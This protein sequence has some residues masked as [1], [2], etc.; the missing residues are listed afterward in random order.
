MAQYE[1]RL[2]ISVKNID[3][4]QKLNDI[5]LEPFGIHA[6]GNEAFNLS[7]KDWLIDD[8]S[9]TEK[10]LKKF[11]MELSERL[12]R[13]G[14]I[15]ADTTNINEDPY[16]YVV[17]FAGYDVHAKRFNYDD[18][19]FEAPIDNLAEYLNYGKHFSFSFDEIK[20][21]KKFGIRTE[22]EGRNVIYKEILKNEGLVDEIYLADTN[23]DE[24]IKNIES[25][26]VG[27]DVTL[28]HK[29]TEEYN[30]LIEV[31]KE[32]KTIGLLDFRSAKIMAPI[33]DEGEQEFE[34]RIVSVL[35]L[36]KRKKGRHS[37]IVSIH[38]ELIIPEEK[39]I[40][41]STANIDSDNSAFSYSTIDNIDP[42]FY[43]G[44]CEK[45]NLFIGPD[46]TITVAKNDITFKIQ[47]KTER[48]MKNINKKYKKYL[49]GEYGE[50]N[51]Y[52]PYIALDNL[53][54]SDYEDHTESP[55]VVEKSTETLEPDQ[56]AHRVKV[57]SKI[58]EMMKDTKNLG[59][60]IDAVPKKKNN[61]L[62]IRRVTPITSMFVMT[63]DTTMLSLCA[64]ATDDK[65]LTLEIRHVLNNN[66]DKFEN[67]I[68][69]STNLFR[70]K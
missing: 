11:V 61:T 19:C 68:V 69:M 50:G 21:L 57:F 31:F 34:S 37:A 51:Y 17:Y 33:L 23:T 29:G 55:Y 1:S 52:D 54:Q 16:A 8:W 20:M 3:A 15:F 43:E 25:L 48:M 5:D 28:I 18:F 64:K 27:D 10:D 2:R 42:R 47:I 53:V 30:N 70:T 38:I 12:G 32:G 59:M 63:F 26:S 22:K 4:W 65:E 66:S 58:V 44:I 62:H 14:L 39:E 9:C 41:N 40:D 49:K 46:G 24:R 7:D 56:I 6:K 60:L 36:S 67:D 35:P 45:G 13:D